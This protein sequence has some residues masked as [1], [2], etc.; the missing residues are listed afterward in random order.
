[1]AGE[2]IGLFRAFNLLRQAVIPAREPSIRQHRA[3][4]GALHT[5][6]PDTGETDDLTGGTENLYTEERV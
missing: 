1:M 2:K 5:R 6:L 3:A 4:R